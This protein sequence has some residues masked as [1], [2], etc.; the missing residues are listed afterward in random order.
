VIVGV[1]NIYASEALHRA[2]LS[3]RRSALRLGADRAGRLAAAVTGVLSE[4]I[5]AGGSSLRDYVRSDGSQ[6]YFQHRFA[7]YDR[8]AQPCLRTGCGGVIRRIVQS[9]R[10]TF[11]CP[12][13]QR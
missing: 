8:A 5:E 6:G 2:R 4:A 10:S 13:C 7:V 1:G 9:N 12:A 3:P 11:Y